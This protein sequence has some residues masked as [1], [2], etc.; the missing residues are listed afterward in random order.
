LIYHRVNATGLWVHDYHGAGVTTKSVNRHAT[1][2][3]IFSG[4]I[5]FFDHRL[6]AV[7]HGFFSG[8]LPSYSSQAR[9]L[10]TASRCQTSKFGAATARLMSLSAATFLSFGWMPGRAESR[11]S[12]RD[13]DEEKQSGYKSNSTVD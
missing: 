6:H 5:I 1:Y 12:K 3:R 13:C 11:L 2:F 10:S 7:T 9:S 8:A 4:G